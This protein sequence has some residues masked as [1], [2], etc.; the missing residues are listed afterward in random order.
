MHKYT[1]DQKDFIEKNAFGKTTDELTK[2]VNEKFEIELTSK[3]VR[4][5]KKNNK[6]K[7]GIDARFKKGR[8]PYTKGKKRT[9]DSPTEFKKGHIPHNYLPVGTER[10]NG[11][12]Y[13]DIKVSDPN[14]WKAKHIM[15]WEEHNGPV[16]AGKI[17]IF[18]DKDRRNFNINNLI[19][20]SRGQLATLNVKGLIMNDAELTKTGIVIADTVQKISKLKRRN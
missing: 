2:L 19:C 10:V 11:D 15:V 14:K 5:F 12:D 1:A 7:S 16:P 3:Q 4:I 17:I 8:I 20:I 13:V 18:G 6:I 9:W